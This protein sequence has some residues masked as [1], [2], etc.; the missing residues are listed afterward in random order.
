[1]PNNKKGTPSDFVP[2]SRQLLIS[3]VSLALIPMIIVAAFTYLHASRD[4]VQAASEKL[5]L[6][7]DFQQ[8]F[9][10]NWFDYRRM[11][12]ERLAD[13][14]EVLGFLRSTDEGNEYDFENSFERL[15]ELQDYVGDLSE[16]YDYIQG[17][18]LVDRQAVIRYQS[19]EASEH[20]HFINDGAFEQDSLSR[21]IQ[22]SMDNKQVRFTDVLPSHPG[23]DEPVAMLVAPVLGPDNQVMGAVL[24]CI[25]LE[26]IFQSLLSTSGSEISTY[27]DGS[28]QGLR[29]PLRSNGYTDVLTRKMTLAELPPHYHAFEIF[30]LDE[31]VL[32][33]RVYQA[34]E[35]IGSKGN[36]VI[37]ITDIVNLFGVEWTIVTE[38]DH[39]MITMPAKNSALITGALSLVL[40][41]LVVIVARIQ[42][43]NITR[44]IA[45]L[46][47]VT[48]AVSEG[49]LDIR[50]EESGRNEVTIL[51]R[52]FNEMLDSWQQTELAL[53]ASNQ[54]SHEAILA[55]NEQKYALDQHAIVAMTDVKGTITMVNESFQEISGYDADEL[56]G[57][58][59][60][61]LNSGYHDEDFWRDMFK[62]I[63]HGVTWRGEICNRAKSGA[64]YWVDSTIVPLVRDGK[65]QSYVAIRTDIT[66][67]KLAQQELLEAKNAAEQAAKIKSEFLAIMSHEIRTPMNGVLG[68]LK[69]LMKTKLDDAQ[70]RQA[71]LAYGSAEALLTIIND[72]LDFSKIEA[73]KLELESLDFDLLALFSEFAS[74]NAPRIHEKGLEFVL[75]LSG[76]D[77]DFVIG[78]PGRLRQ[79]LINLVG[80]A[81][82][83]TE[84]G[85]IRLSARLIQSYNGVVK[86]ECS[87]FDTG[88]G[89]PDDKVKTLF[90]SFSQVDAST[91]RKYGGTGLGLT[92]VKQLCELMGGG[93]QVQ[94]KVGEGSDFSFWI[95]VQDSLSSTTVSKTL[96]RVPPV[97]VLVMVERDSQ[98]KVLAE[99]MR[100]WGLEVEVAD[101]TEHAMSCLQARAQEGLPFDIVFIDLKLDQNGGEEI[102]SMISQ[103]MKLEAP[104]LVALPESDQC[105]ETTRLLAF[106]YSGVVSK[107]ATPSDLFDTLQ[108]VMNGDTSLTSAACGVKEIKNDTPED[109]KTALASVVPNTRIL[110]VED[111]SVNQLV[112]SAM[113]EQLG[114]SCDL[115]GNGLEAISALEQSPIDM[116][117]HLVLMDCQ[118]PEMDGYEATKAIR[119][120]QAGDRYQNISIIAMTANAMK[121]D[122]E[123]CLAAGMSDYLSKPIN[124][125]ALAEMLGNYLVDKDHIATAPVKDTGEDVEEGVLVWDRDTALEYLAGNESLLNQ[126]VSAGLED[127]PANI[128]GLERGISSNDY[129]LARLSAHSIKGVAASMGAMRLRE[130]AYAAEQAAVEHNLSEL[131]VHY[132]KVVGDFEAF[133]EEVSKL[134]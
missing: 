134:S 83:F 87:V 59:H 103:L 67:A 22:S 73:G 120:G 118:M 132:E 35:M 131:G 6:A 78:D 10:S 79:I 39:H 92:I 45:D 2:L 57:Q 70:M 53:Q 72:I 64:L 41:C 110:L 3:L 33:G 84:S 115:A 29:S 94:S 93:I 97:R 23:S 117:Y 61:M 31:I 63:G 43:R 37:A 68:M 21:T 65:P 124:E 75:D 133:N 114:F 44:P 111:N 104:K 105:I 69:L 66:L 76:I 49:D 52:H 123:K 5:V 86:L 18:Y 56:I 71:R 74:T 16:G 62:T 12:I 28:D 58:N 122:K 108:T 77:R 36:E 51:A 100:I 85:E 14:P 20:K 101:N 7:S 30:H 80:N 32:S 24:M 38:T 121:G 60:R 90:E 46:E 26:R 15:K 1:M 50:A 11:D 125:Q 91:T 130:S 107:P 13:S 9:V 82:K 88:I 128:E 89:I 17:V 95:T 96:K 25:R 34:R 126:V 129:D 27:I 4:L 112:A 127:I 54:A 42:A 47:A 55:L 119:N 81:I 19:E 40:M 109:L 102:A 8:R 99:Q 116:P 98:R 106:G 48:D 113:L